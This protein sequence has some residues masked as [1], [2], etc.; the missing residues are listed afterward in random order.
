MALRLDSSGDLAPVSKDAKSA[1]NMVQLP[2]MLMTRKTAF[3]LFEISRVQQP[4][5]PSGPG[6]ESA[7]HE[8]SLRGPP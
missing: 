3:I 5:M 1:G 8:L 6:H 7:Y 2:Q 4:M